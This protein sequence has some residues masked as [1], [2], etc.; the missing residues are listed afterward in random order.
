MTKTRV[1][2]SFAL[3][4][5]LTVLSVFA[6]A[7]CAP[8]E[9]A[10]SSRP[11]A[12]PS[13]GG[14]GPATPTGPATPSGSP[15]VAATPTTPTGSPA[16]PAATQPA[17]S[18]ASV[19]P[20]S[21]PVGQAAQPVTPAAPGATS[22]TITP[23]A[24]GGSAVAA[25]AVPA[26]TPALRVGEL[27]FLD[28]S[29]AIHRR[30]QVIANPD[31]GDV[32][33]PFDV[34]V[35]GA[36]SRAEID[37]GSGRPGGATIRLAENTAFYYDTRALSADERR[38]VLQL[39]SGAI[40]IKVDRL[41]NGSFSIATDNT[42]LGVRGTTFI[43]DTIPDGTALVTCAEG[44][45]QVKG[46]G[47]SALLAQPGTVVTATAT[48]T[49]QARP[50]DPAG[51]SGFRTTWRDDAYRAFASQALFMI[52]A[53]AATMERNAPLLS[54]A[55]ARLQA[56]RSVLQTWREARDAGRVPRFTDWTAEKRALAPVLFDCLSAMFQLERAYYRLL[57][58][59]SLH[60]G[61]G[62]V[63]VGSLPD[64]R[65][66]LAFF[67]DFE[68]RNRNVLVQMAEVRDVLELFIYASAGSPMGGFFADKV[69]A[70]GSGG[71][72]LGEED[73]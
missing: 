43:V 47:G 13:S 48:G 35:T 21:S 39:L 9:A 11:E 61:P 24:T 37:I 29:V 44:R 5:S 69:A 66:S 63:G 22:A 56:Q 26:A 64:G 50:V 38:T 41:V 67:R 2:G 14:P 12:A 62:R 36:G 31:I 40:A 16:A 55:H 71:L 7:G 54:A 70:L 73:W 6:L 1:R 58:L 33:E 28:G 27:V 60:D 32:V 25:P 51:L 30:G 17:A 20:I 45:V 46:Q 72:F 15:A 59:R 3:V 4:L 49:A 53:H 18:P 10:V 34:I 8:Q 42:V 65:T 19:A 68:S 52:S 23:P 57:E